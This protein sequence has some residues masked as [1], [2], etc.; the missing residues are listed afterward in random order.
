MGDELL[1]EFARF[2][3]RHLWVRGLDLFLE[4]AFAMTLTAAA[5]LLVDRLAFELGFAEPHLSTRPWIAVLMGG[6]LA[7]AGLVAAAIL[8]IRPVRPAELA[9]TLDRATGGEE[10]FLSALELAAAGG[11]GSF[12]GPLFRD[13]AR[14]AH[15]A[16]PSDVLPRAPLGHR[17]G[18]ALSLVVAGVLYAFPAQPYAAPVADFEASTLRGPAPLEVRFE[19]ASLG[20]LRGFTWDF[21]D[22]TT[23]EG[24]RIVHSFAKPG[25][26]LVRL[27]VVGPGGASEKERA[28]RVLPA[29]HAFADFRG[30]PLRGRERLAVR[31]ENLSRNAKRFEWDFGDG[32][33][34]TEPDPVHL[35]EGGGRYTVRLRALNDV[36]DDLCV[37]EDYVRIAHGDEPLADFRA[38]PVEGE[39]PLE[40]AFEHLAT[41]KVM[42]FEWDFGDVYGDR[43]S[44]DPNPAHVF[45]QPGQYTV[46]L[47]V[48]GPHG[49]DA[50][51]KVRYIKVREKGDGPGKGGGGKDGQGPKPRP[52]G[53]GGTEG[54]LEG[55]R[56]PPRKVEF[57][58]EGI[59]SHKPGDEAV[60]KVLRTVTDDPSGTGKPQERPLDPGVLQQY[61]RAAEDSIQRERIPP[62][63]R[64]Y[65]RR[66]Y[67]SL[68]PK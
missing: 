48:S 6:T 14:V 39:A 33:V 57:V 58:P 62:S 29:D 25:E 34:S 31:F 63:L 38:F 18:I 1:R 46:R 32:A 45:G 2:R 40:V 21:G 5:M 10:R 51:E 43:R 54:R 42:S 16:R 24:E 36:G 59:R 64:D 26:Y 13:A 65:I 68:T 23:G 49:E 37:R 53:A 44:T 60:E 55:P 28:V 17:G 7:L 47:R 50:A 9:W 20:A 22:G 61:K 35:Y 15:D 27:R 52:Q 12:A 11:G 30:E 56:T 66:Y 8:R 19:D 67:E 4:A 41:G 3:R